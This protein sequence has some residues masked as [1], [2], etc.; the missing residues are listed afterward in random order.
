MTTAL[1]IF[2]NGVP[3]DVAPESDVSA[4]LRSHDPALADRVAAGAAV[5]TDARGIEIGGSQRLA[6]GSILRVVVRAK[7]GAGSGD[8]DA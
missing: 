1:R 6:A 4:A 3:V 5:V 8:A 2:I 7:R